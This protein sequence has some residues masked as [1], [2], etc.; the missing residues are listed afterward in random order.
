LGSAVTALNFE[1]SRQQTERQI[2]AWSASFAKSVIPNLIETDHLPIHG[3]L[4]FVEDSGLFK[5]G[6]ITDR[7]ERIIS[8]FTFNADRIR[9]PAVKNPIRDENGVVWGY[10]DLEGGA[11]QALLPSA[12]LISLFTLVILTFGI[13]IFNSVNNRIAKEVDL[14]GSFIEKIDHLTRTVKDQPA[15]DIEYVKNEIL[16]ASALTPEI[17][18]IGQSSARLL[19]QIVSAERRLRNVTV[20]AERA[21]TVNEL[22]RAVSHDIQSPLGA[23]EALVGGAM[24][25]GESRDLILMVL[26]RIR[27]IAADLLQKTRPVSE[28]QREFSPST[29]KSLGQKQLTVLSICQKIAQEKTLEYQRPKKLFVEIIDRGISDLIWPYDN[30]LIERI[31]SN[32]INNS[33]EATKF[34]ANVTIELGLAESILSLKLIDNGSGMPPH[35]VDQFNAGQF[36]FTNEFKNGIGLKTAYSIITG[37]GGSLRFGVC[38][39]GGTSVTIN[40]PV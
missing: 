11:V 36:S 10:Y 13:V 12:L 4:H 23:L 3:K 34:D 29:A 35:L 30:R 19:D 5:S 17:R 24:L 16:V 7:Y 18:K 37:W 14:L 27:G 32:L 21:R 38:T 6:Y 26:D 33:V 25:S 39:N 1:L 40:V 8:Q 31:L 20:E 28:T 22:C 9:Y 2:A 15:T